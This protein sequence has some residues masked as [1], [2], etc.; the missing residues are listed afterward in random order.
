MSKGNLL[1][2]V[3]AL[4]VPRYAVHRSGAV[5]GQNGYNVLNGFGSQPHQNLPYAS[6]FKLENSRSLPLGQHFV[7][8]GVVY[9]YFVYIEV[10]IC[11][12]DKI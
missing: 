12:A 7:H 11:S 9:W 5:Q 2:V 4:D 6:T 3:A 10:G 8:L 1:R